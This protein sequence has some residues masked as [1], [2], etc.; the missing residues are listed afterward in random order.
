MGHFEV[1][2][3][4]PSFGQRPIGRTWW[5]TGFGGLEVG[6][7]L[8]WIG[9]RTGLPS[10]PATR[11]R[12]N[13]PSLC[14]WRFATILFASS[15]DFESRARRDLECRSRIISHDSTKT[16]KHSLHKFTLISLGLYLHMTLS[17]IH[18]SCLSLFNSYI[19]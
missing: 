10:L 3:F 17:G 15:I 18:I 9:S 1:N 13:F 8:F 19:T 2:A 6:V 11:T 4:P 5:E 12:E 7:P 14:C 16:L